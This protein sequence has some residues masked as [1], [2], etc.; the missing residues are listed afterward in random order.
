MSESL[1]FHPNGLSFLV[2]LNNGEQFAETY[3]SV[4]GG[5]VKQENIETSVKQ[6]AQLP[7]PVNTASDLLHWCMKT[8]LSIHEVVMENEN[9]WRSEVET[10]AGLLRIFGVMRIAFLPVV[11]QQVCYPG[12]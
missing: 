11:I 3:Y 1:P 5:F 6:T 7:F 4:G 2:T 12:D 10:R 9:A 8:G